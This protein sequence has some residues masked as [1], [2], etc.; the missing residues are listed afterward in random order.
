MSE[1]SVPTNVVKLARRINGILHSDTGIEILV[2]MAQMS[3]D[4]QDILIG[5]AE[6]I[7][8]AREEAQTYESA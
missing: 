7:Q 8:A 1:T 4:Q 6:E 3:S 2:R 5:K